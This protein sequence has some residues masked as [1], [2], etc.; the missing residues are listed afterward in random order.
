MKPP[1]VMVDVAEANVIVFVRVERFDA[2]GSVT[3]PPLETSN[4]MFAN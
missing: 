3:A 2:N 4:K 1:L